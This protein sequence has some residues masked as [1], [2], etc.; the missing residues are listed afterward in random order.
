MP[1][2]KKKK[3]LKYVI[4]PYKYEFELMSN[5]HWLT[6]VSDETTGTQKNSKVHDIN[7]LGV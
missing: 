7:V 3:N 5:T 1:M 2:E 4:M 6:R